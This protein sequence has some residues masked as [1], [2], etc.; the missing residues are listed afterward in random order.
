MERAEFLMFLAVCASIAA[1]PFTIRTARSR[2]RDGATDWLALVI[3]MAFAATSF[4]LLIA[5]VRSLGDGGG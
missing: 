2:K 3:S 4:L 5:A 1:V